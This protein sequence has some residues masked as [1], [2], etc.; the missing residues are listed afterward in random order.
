MYQSNKKKRILKDSDSQGW[1]QVGAKERA[2][3]NKINNKRQQGRTPGND[4]ETRGTDGDETI[5]CNRG[6]HQEERKGVLQ[7][8]ELHIQTLMTYIYK[9][10]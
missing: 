9:R 4:T 5:Q 2:L 6:P 1:F 8:S 7:Q 10:A 3:D